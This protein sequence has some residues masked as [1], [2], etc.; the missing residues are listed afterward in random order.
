MQTSPYKLI[1]CSVRLKVHFLRWYHNHSKFILVKFVGPNMSLA[2]DFP[3]GSCLRSPTLD[4]RANFT[5]Q[6]GSCEIKLGLNSFFLR[7]MKTKIFEI[8]FNLF[9]QVTVPISY[10][11]YVSVSGSV[12][13]PLYL[14]LVLTSMGLFYVNY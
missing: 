12:L 5:L 4:T 9:K 3:L 7:V 6:V 11:D 1:S 2:I 8:D 13:F 14:F 10:Y